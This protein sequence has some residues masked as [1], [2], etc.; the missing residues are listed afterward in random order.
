MPIHLIATAAGQLLYEACRGVINGL[1][2]GWGEH[3]IKGVAQRRDD[4]L[5]QIIIICN[6]SRLNL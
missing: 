2:K 5:L 1:T 6:N 3:K 4:E